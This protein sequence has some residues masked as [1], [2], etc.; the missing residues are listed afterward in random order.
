MRKRIAFFILIAAWLSACGQIFPEPQFQTQ[1]T[2]N[3]A[4]PVLAED[5]PEA[6]RTAQEYLDAWQLEDYASMYR[7]LT[8]ISQDAVNEDQ[9]TAYYRSVAAEAALAPYEDSSIISYEILS[10][11]TQPTN[12]Q[13]SYRVTLHS[14]LVGDIRRE[15]QMNLSLE[16]GEWRIQWSETLILPDLV[17]GNQLKM[18]HRSPSRGNIYD[19]N[20]SALVAQSS[21]VAIGLDTTR[22]DPAYLEEFLA[23]LEEMSQGRI[24][25]E[26][27]R[28][29]IEQ[30]QELGWYLPI[31]DF[32]TETVQEYND[33]LQTVPGVILRSFQGRYYYDG[34][35][36]S[37]AP[38]V[39][40]YMSVIQAGQEEFYQRLGYTLDER[41]GSGGLEQWGEPY[42]GGT[43]GGVLYVVTPSGSTV[44]KLA[45]K[46]VTPAQS[47]YTT[48]DKDFQAEVQKALNEMRGAIV[49]LERDTGRV[50]AM[51]SS[52]GFN[53]NL[54]EPSNFN[55]EALVGTLYNQD[56]P[57]LNRATQGQYPLGSVF[58]ILTMAAGLESGRYTIDTPYN[59][60]YFFNEIP[61]VT[62]NDWTYEYFLVDRRTQATGLI[63]LS[64]ALTKSCN[65]YFWHI[66]LDLFNAGQTTT[67]SDMAKAFGLGSRTG[68]E[69]F[70]AA[71]QIPIPE[72]QIDSTNYAIGQGTTLVT[73]LQVAN[74]VAAVGNG[75]KL[76]QPQLV[77]RI[78]PPD[79]EPTHVFTPTLLS[80][81]PI[82][83]EHLEAIQ[84]A[85]TAVVGTQ[86]TARSVGAYLNSYNIPVA[87][88]TGTAQSG[89]GQPHAW[90]AGYTF[91]GREDRADIAVA[92]ILE[93][94]GEGSVMAAPV[95][96]GIIKLYFYGPPRNTF[97]WE[98]EPGVIKQ[99]EAEELGE[100]EVSP[101][102]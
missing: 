87:G 48:L 10:V 70:E 21:A 90:F 33:T 43:R 18:E 61:G 72:S 4:P 5:L 16:A 9:F 54:F 30:Y 53:P 17:D 7:L 45:E 44:T 26:N 101:T 50:I 58:K 47:I 36:V 6:V 88:K 66:G 14:R 77:E 82:S 81:L 93:N 80:E 65:P 3:Q 52:P 31:G 73:P 89:Q 40:G 102:P 79:G 100:E 46:G 62:L 95:F 42:L 59:C 56:N 84:T 15:T 13:V 76:F 74:F 55:S 60:G 38:H 99:P 98:I 23:T 11:L 22:F 94:T 41:V 97:P 92:V 71:G 83:A 27:L 85:M 78:T 67:V 75:G 64:Q 8:E 32:S 49:V 19:R 34:G 1:P 28:P 37:I 63:N 20:G 57:L 51:A 25:A 96:Q 12:A 39:T 86:G 24:V 35:M 91:A 29:K 69:I 68:I 2:L